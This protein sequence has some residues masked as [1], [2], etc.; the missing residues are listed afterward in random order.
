[1]AYFNSHLAKTPPMGWNSWDCYSVSITEAEFKENADFIAKNLKQF[2]WEYV[3]LDLAWFAPGATHSNYK[4]LNI[5]MVY[6]GYGRLLP[7]PEKFPSSVNGKGLKPLA[8]YVHSLGL[9]FGI[10]I[11]R[12]IPMRAVAD[13]TPI[14]GTSV[15]ADQISYERE[16]CPWFNSLRTLDFSKPEA[17]SYYDSI[18]ELYAQWGVDYIKADD[19]NSW[20]EVENSNGSPT[21]NGSPYRI[22]DIEAIS[23]SIK[24]CGRDMILSLSPGGPETTLINHLRSNAN[25][26]RISAD[27]WDEWG[28]L[29]TQMGR[30]ATWAPFITEGHWP[31][32]DML[33]VGYLPR[34]ESVGQNRTSNFN[35][36][37]LHTLLSM[38]CMARSPLMIGADLPRT[39]AE[40]IKILSNQAVLDVNQHST[41][42][43]LAKSEND[44]DLW[45]A[46]STKSSTKYLAIFN[47]NDVAKA[48]EVNLASIDIQNAKNIKDLW[49]RYEVNFDNGLITVEINP[50]DCVLLAVN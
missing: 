25:L 29:K 30:C 40:T 15:T 43:K 7:C 45:T 14:K 37:E 24:T 17:Q 10:H 32:A 36:N 13:K 3:V 47:K 4:K 28:S 50:H 46:K 27:F 39:D 8:D 49:Q 23:K 33:P 18:F 44:I 19:V 16:A 9:K 11:M 31:D 48:V 5:D 26:W 41:G 42:N 12:G 20:H 1:M 21:G 34:G 6:D 22:D 38:W 35:N 2:G